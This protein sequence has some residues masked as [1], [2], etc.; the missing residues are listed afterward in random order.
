MLLPN[1]AANN[2]TEKILNQAEAMKCNIYLSG[3]HGRG[4]LNKEAFERKGIEV[5]FQN[6]DELFKLY[7]QSILSVISELGIVRTIEILRS[8]EI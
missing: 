5:R 6:T 8:K 3:P 7:P 1:T 2:A 4:Y